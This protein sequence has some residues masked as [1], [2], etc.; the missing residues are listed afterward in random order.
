MTLDMWPDIPGSSFGYEGLMLVNPWW[1]DPPQS[2]GNSLVG[3]VT[4]HESYTTMSFTVI[5]PSVFPSV[6]RFIVIIQT[7]LNPVLFSPQ[8]LH[9]PW[10]GCTLWMPSL[11]THTIHGL[12]NPT[13]SWERI[14]RAL[15]CH[16]LPEGRIP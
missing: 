11:D 9:T 4:V 8:V 5:S 12:C 14:L 3:D 1:M 6:G 7:E 13:I 10:L 2:I 15:L 16:P